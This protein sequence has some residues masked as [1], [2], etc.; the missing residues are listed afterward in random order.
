[1]SPGARSTEFWVS[2]AVIVWGGALVAL[3]VLWG[4]DVLV[5]S[6]VALQA[7]VAVGYQHSRGRSKAPRPFLPPRGG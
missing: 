2:I 1:M 4:W 3:G 6:G 5:V 7:L